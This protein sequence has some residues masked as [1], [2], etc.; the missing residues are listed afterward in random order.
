MMDQFC[1]ALACSPRKNGNTEILLQAAVERL[2]S[3][4]VETETIHL[5]DLSYSPCLACEGCY[6]TGR[7]VITDEAGPVFEK[8]L[9]ADI[10]I[11]AAPVF[12]MG[13]CAQAKML[14]DRSQQFWATRYLLKQ[15]VIQDDDLRQNRRGIFISCAG[16]RLP[17]VF[18]GSITVA[19]YFFKM[20]EVKLNGT[21][22]YP[23]IDKK[24]EILTRAGALEEIKDVSASLA[25]K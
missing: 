9:R 11:L 25:A 19:R 5:G 15:P 16:T 17:G 2:Q 12:S 20:M 10:L 1:V 13:I 18:E 7:C 23:G 8:I 14:I 4:N 3:L 22:C 24:G 6:S 21:Y